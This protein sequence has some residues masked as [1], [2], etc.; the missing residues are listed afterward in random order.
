MRCELHCILVGFAFFFR[1]NSLIPLKSELG[2]TDR[3]KCVTKGI[4]TITI[5][6]NGDKRTNSLGLLD[7]VQ[8]SVIIDIRRLYLIVLN[9]IRQV[10][11]YRRAVIN[12]ITFTSEN[13][14]DRLFTGI[15][16]L[17]VYS[18]RGLENMRECLNDTMVSYSNCT[19]AEGCGKLNK[20]SWFARSVTLAHLSVNMKLDSF[21]LSIILSLRRLFRTEES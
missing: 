3:R 18:F 4:I 5:N 14:F 12:K 11:K 1:L 9:I 20:I 19:V 2:C 10:I 13:A 7:K 17:L 8:R 16:A 21:A 6:Y 15:L